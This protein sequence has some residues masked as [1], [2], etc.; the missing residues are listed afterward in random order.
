[1]S[2]PTYIVDGDSLLVDVIDGDAS[3]NSLVDGDEGIY[4]STHSEA[5]PEY[6][7]P[8]EVT[9]SSEAQTLSTALK[10]V[11]A[12]IVINPIPNNYGLIE[13]NGSTLTVS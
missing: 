10:S 3:L 11:L 9:P 1:M 13:W 7:G 8:V 12:D 5:L 6:T 2:N 4:I